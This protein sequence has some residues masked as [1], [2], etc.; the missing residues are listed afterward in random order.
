LLPDRGKEILRRLS[1]FAGGFTLEA[2][3][4]VASGAG[5]AEWDIVRGVGDLVRRSMLTNG[6]DLVNPRHRMLETM[7]AFALEALD[8]AGER[9]VVAR[10]HAEYVCRLAE[11]ADARW[12]TS[13]D[14]DWTARLAPELENLRAALEWALGEAGAPRLGAQ[15]AA[16]S[17]RFWFE[18]SLLSE[19]RAWLTRA[20]D[21][22]PPDL[23]V[24]SLI[25]LKRGLAD[26][27]VDA[28]AAA[29]AAEAALAL[30][31]G[32]GEAESLGVCLRA[33]AAARYR[34]GDYASAEALTHRASQALSETDQPRTFA[35]GLA[36]L[37]ILRGVAGD[38]A[39]ARRLNALAQTRL[40]ALGDRR[41]AAIC[42]Q[43]AA[44]FEFAAGESAAA[45]TLADDSVAL[46][47]TRGGRYHLGIGLGNLAAYRLARR[48]PA[49]AAEAARE[50]LTIASE[51]EDAAGVVITLETLALAL[52]QL[53]AS[54]DAAR[55]HGFVEAAQARLGLARQETEQVTHDR[56]VAALSGLAGADRLAEQGRHLDEASAI[57]L[58]LQAGCAA[59]PE[60]VAV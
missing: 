53:G 38:H 51:I 18:S 28:A 17:A 4:Q 1:V 13:G 15:L 7:R 26:L 25:R 34:L 21:R 58:A 49:G 27:C 60:A 47:R 31:R 11:A 39:E 19:G 40:Q 22:A 16:A 8:A 57:R 37:S 20:L 33:L 43:Y 46:F 35:E 10:K 29:R 55:L 14:L 23:D 30:A 36:D 41:R 56:L 54:P 32:Q 48:D 24:A 9:E 2:A 3:Q 52:A 12:E 45:E 5:I 44:E 6:P 42:L 50:A 59:V